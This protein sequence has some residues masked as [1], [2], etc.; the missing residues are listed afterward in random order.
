L[1]ESNFDLVIDLLSKIDDIIQK[2]QFY[3]DNIKLQEHLINRSE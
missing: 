3:Q 1:S 2:E